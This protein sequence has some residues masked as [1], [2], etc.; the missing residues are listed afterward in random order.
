MLCVTLYL[1][2][3]ALDL[4]V[5]QSQKPSSSLKGHDPTVQYLQR[6]GPEHIDLIFEY[7]EWVLKASPADGSKVLIRAR[8]DCLSVSYRLSKLRVE[9]VQL[10]LYMTTLCR[11]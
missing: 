6:L 8:G 1:A 9:C 2:L 4:L 11:Q 5:R 3:V 10:T 7:A